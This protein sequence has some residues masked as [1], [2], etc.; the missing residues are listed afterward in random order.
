MSVRKNPE[1]KERNMGL[2]TDPDKP[3]RGQGDEWEE[4]ADE[5]ASPAS[6]RAARWWWIAA[7]AVV[8]SLIA[9][10]WWGPWRAGSPATPSAAATSQATLDPGLMAS[11]WPQ[12]ALDALHTEHGITALSRLLLTSTQI[13][14]TGKAADGAWQDYVYV[15]DTAVSLGDPLTAPTSAS[16]FALADV[17]GGQIGRAVADVMGDSPRPVAITQVVV[18]RDT[19]AQGN[20]ITIEVYWRNAAGLQV[21]RVAAQAGS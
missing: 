2:A 6:R 9:V 12:R 5:L 21:S 1:A 7:G 13:Q 11:P 18:Q 20:P 10:A 4:L 16:A 3:P 8:A 17:S 15:E 19:V 14:A